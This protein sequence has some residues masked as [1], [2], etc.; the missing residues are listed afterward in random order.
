MKAETLE[1]GNQLKK[2]L[3]ELTNLLESS[4]TGIQDISQLR[5]GVTHG[6][7]LGTDTK[8]IVLENDLAYNIYKLIRKRIEELKNIKQAEFDEFGGEK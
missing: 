5:I 2:E 3:T 7:G 6:Y 1:K 4:Y 8:L